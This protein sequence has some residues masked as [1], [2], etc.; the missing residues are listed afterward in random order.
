MKTIYKVTPLLFLTLLISNLN[1]CQQEEGFFLRKKVIK[2]I[3]PG[4]V[5]VIIPKQEDKNIVYQRPLPFDQL[6]YKQRNDKF[7]AIGT[8]FFISP[9]RL[10]SAAHVI[11]ADN[12]STYKDFKI[13]TNDGEVYDI[14]KIYRYSTYRDVIE[15]ELKSYPKKVTTLKLQPRVEIGDMVY[16]VGNAGGEGISTRGGQVSTFTP[17]PVSGQWDYIRFS[18][19][20]S[21]GNSGGPLV[22][23]KGEVVGMS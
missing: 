14:G 3:Y 18:S 20:A 15:F 6:D 21:P 8:A 22:N 2:K 1:S 4:I 5:E 10:I 19:P 13:R 11:A 7:Y 17:E 12:Y 23:Y 16:A 9:T